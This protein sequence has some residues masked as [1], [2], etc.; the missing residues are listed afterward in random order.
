M[1]KY[2]TKSK[3]KSLNYETKLLNMIRE[4]EHPEKARMLAIETILWY[5][6]R[7]ES[8]EAPISVAPRE[9]V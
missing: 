8:F 9:Q 1:T 2:E 6:A 3:T 7:R 4:H 5:L